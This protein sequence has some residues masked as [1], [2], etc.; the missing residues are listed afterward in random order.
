MLSTERLSTLIS[1][2]PRE[3]GHWLDDLI[4]KKTKE[5]VTGRV[6]EPGQVVR[7]EHVVAKEQ[8]QIDEFTG[9]VEYTVEYEA[10][11]L[12]AW[13][14]QQLDTI[15]RDVSEFGC[16]CVCPAGLVVFVARLEAKQGE[17]VRVCVIGT[18][19]Q[20]TVISAVGVQMD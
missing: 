11:V 20:A 18:R 14:G 10:T 8:I 12:N 3:T 9:N 13:Q 1:I 5:T 15:V 2:L 6:F 17:A 19:K 4:L 7:V 16:H